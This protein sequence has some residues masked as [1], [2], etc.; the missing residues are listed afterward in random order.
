M[1]DIILHNY[2]QSPVAEKTRKAF[3][4]KDLEWANVTIPRIPPK[5]DLL[6]LTG[7]YRRTPVM[8]IGADI[9]CDSQ[10]VLM[11]LDRR[12][13]EPPFQANWGEARWS[14]EILFGLA[15]KLVLGGNADDLPAEFAKDRGRL[16][17]GPNPDWHEVAKDLPHVIAQLRGALG[18]WQAELSN[19][20]RF[21]SGNTAGLSDILA[22]Y[23]VWFIRR[24][25][26]GG[27]D[28]LGQFPAITDWESRMEAIGHGTASE[29]TSVEALTVARNSET[30]CEAY[31]DPNDPQGLVTG[32]KVFITP[33]SDGGD[34]D[35]TGFVRYAD[36]QTIAIMREDPQTGEVCVHFPRV[37]YRV[38]AD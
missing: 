5:P 37:G 10:C 20:A 21:L 30:V 14:D 28:L 32:Q 2:P 18:W 16:Y 24:R 11:E 1:T 12:F 8:Q 25:W 19:D 31:V 27:P 17:I 38:I 34:P 29:L 36:H 3:G 22:W 26:A 4:V 9:Y 35:V 23:V 7:G 6:P 15:V 33:D 13:P